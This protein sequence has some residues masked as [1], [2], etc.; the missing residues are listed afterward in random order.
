MRPAPSARFPISLLT[1][2]LF[3]SPSASEIGALKIFSTTSIS[4]SSYAS[5]G[6]YDSA[7]H[8]DSRNL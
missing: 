7:L 8:V 6:A 1:V 4:K 3:N 5:G 2:P